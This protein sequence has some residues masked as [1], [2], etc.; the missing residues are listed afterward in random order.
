MRNGYLI[1]VGSDGTVHVSTEWAPGS[2][3]AAVLDLCGNAIGHVANISPL[4]EK[5]HF[6]PAKP[7][8]TKPGEELAKIDPQISKPATAD[9]FQGAVLITMHIAIPARGVLGL[10]QSLKLPPEPKTR[11]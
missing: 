11:Q 9:R 6:I 5:G 1:A 2:S 3:G 8:E 7:P 4:T 10:V